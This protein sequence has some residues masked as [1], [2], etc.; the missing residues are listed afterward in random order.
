M[1]QTKR[2]RPDTPVYNPEEPITPTNCPDWLTYIEG[3]AAKI[4]LQFPITLSGVATDTVTMRRPKV[5]DRL[6]A[7][8]MFGAGQEGQR[9]MHFFTSLTELAPEELGEIDLGDYVR[10]QQVFSGFLP[11]QHRRRSGEPS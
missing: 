4:T 9:E 1:T 7:D 8:N 3:G 6:E 11:S 2:T 5:R 10:M